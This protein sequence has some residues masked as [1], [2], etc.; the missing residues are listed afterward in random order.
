MLP[1]GPPSTIKVNSQS[2]ISV[3]RIPQQS[4]TLSNVDKCLYFTEEIYA[5]GTY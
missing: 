2:H 5:V 3:S 1:E 4:V